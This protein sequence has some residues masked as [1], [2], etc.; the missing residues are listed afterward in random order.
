MGEIR[1]IVWGCSSHLYRSLVSLHPS[2]HLHVMYTMFNYHNIH[3]V[4]WNTLMA[5]TCWIYLSRLTLS[6]VAPPHGSKLVYIYI[7]NFTNQTHISYFFTSFLPSLI[8]KKMTYIQAEEKN[9][10]WAW[11]SVTEYGDSLNKLPFVE[12]LMLKFQEIDS[13]GNHRRIKSL[14]V[15]FSVIEREV[16]NFVKYMEQIMRNMLYG[17]LHKWNSKTFGLCWFLQ[18]R[19]PSCK[20]EHWWG[21]LK[22]MGVY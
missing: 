18:S 14:V 16:W 4:S 15:C 22:G 13:G 3:L 20:F 10:C 11:I 6:Y 8:F 7:P 17:V 12:I 21:I 19:G 9:S 5:R 1:G 2:R